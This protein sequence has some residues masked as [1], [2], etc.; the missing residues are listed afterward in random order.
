MTVTGGLRVGPAGHGHG[1]GRIRLRLDFGVV[2]QA[3]APAAAPGPGRWSPELCET[4]AARHRCSSACVTQPQAEAPS[5][6]RD[7]YRGPGRD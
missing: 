5:R 6:I 1:H 2:E 7:R 3:A 4:A